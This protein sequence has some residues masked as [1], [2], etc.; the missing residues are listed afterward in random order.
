[1]K[2]LP[3]FTKEFICFVQEETRR[4]AAAYLTNKDEPTAEF[5]LEKVRKFSY[6][7]ELDKLQTTNPLLLAA[8]VGAISKE[9]IEDYADLS[10]KAF[11]GQNSNDEIDLTPCVVQ[12]MARILRNRFP[13]SVTTLPCMNSMFLWMNRVPGAVIQFNNLIGD[14][15]R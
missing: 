9:N 12:T 6:K 14:S 8:I 2:Y 5:K 1:M 11:G 3:S 10:R 13:R 15:Y 7:R 4:E